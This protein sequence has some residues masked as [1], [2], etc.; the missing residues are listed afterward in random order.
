MTSN[1]KNTATFIHLS[2]LTQY[3]IPFGNYIFPAIIWA[4]KK[5]SSNYINH[6]GKQ[7]LNFQLSIF[8]YSLLLLIV[9][10]PTLLYTFFKNSNFFELIYKH[11]NYSERFN[12]ENIS[13]VVV[14]ACIALLI[15]ALLKIFEFVLILIGA[16]KASEGIEYKY[17]MTIN[18][19]K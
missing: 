8:L 10:I 2:M 15:F 11:N 14:L 19:F 7:A 3:F 13:G 9:S 5:E 4:S 12:L 18:F 16:L 6:H 1:E 17:P